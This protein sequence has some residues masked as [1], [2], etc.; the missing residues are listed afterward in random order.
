M[1]YV[2]PVAMMTRRGVL[3]RPR[4]G[5]SEDGGHRDHQT[6]IAP[7]KAL[8]R[9]RHKIQ[10]AD[11][12]C[13]SKVQDLQPKGLRVEYLGRTVPRLLSFHDCGHGSV[14]LEIWKF[15]TFESRCVD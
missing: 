13:R 14:D 1:R 10:S 3:G 15:L 8:L 4:R 6:N 7:H 11:R 9:P 5:R 2:A 12:S